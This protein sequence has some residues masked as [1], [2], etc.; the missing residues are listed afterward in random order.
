MAILSRS[1]G[2]DTTPTWVTR[3][4]QSALSATH[5][6]PP[7]P[8]GRPSV[9]RRL[10]AARSVAGAS[11][12]TPIIEWALDVG[13]PNL[14][15]VAAWDGIKLA[16]KAAGQL[17]SQLRDHEAEFLVSRG[18]AVLLAIEYLL[19]EGAE[20]GVLEVEAVAEPSSLAH[21]SLTEVN[22]VGAEPWIVFLLNER[23]TRRYIVAV[24]PDGSLL[25]AIGIPVS[26]LER[27]YLPS[28]NNWAL[29]DDANRG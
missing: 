11:A 21:R 7:H 9:S 17:V 26:E 13:I 10:P 24:S 15:P 8:A 27:A 29:P 28:R 6:D 19:D 16:A 23:R 5:S 3:E 2:G 4:I 18:Y 1:G 25:G 22:Y 20:D 14:W 12:W